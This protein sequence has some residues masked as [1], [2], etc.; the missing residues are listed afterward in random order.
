MLPIRLAEPDLSIE[1]TKRR[2]CAAKV[3]PS[4]R[5][6]PDSRIG[7]DGVGETICFTR[8]AAKTVRVE[9][10]DRGKAF[11]DSSVA[12]ARKTISFPHPYSGMDGNSS[13]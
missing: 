3:R 2:Q 7:R 10:S 11:S 13:G 9:L 4:K 6:A 1:K 12:R 5:Q 8:V